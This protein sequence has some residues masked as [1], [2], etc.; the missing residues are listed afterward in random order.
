MTELLPAVLEK[1]S[2]V[3]QERPDFVLAAWPLII[4]PQIATMTQ[5]ISFIEGV[6]LVK[7][8]NSTLHSLLSQKDRSRILNLL[9]M[10]FPKTH[11][12]NIVFRIG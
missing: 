8:K 2:E 9:R 11:I 7:V 5:A 12:K 1:I 3:Y 4:G 6:L 10:K